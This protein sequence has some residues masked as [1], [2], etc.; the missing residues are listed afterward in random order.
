MKNLP[1]L[2][3]SNADMPAMPVLL[4]GQKQEKGDI[5]YSSIAGLTKREEFAKAAMQGLLANPGG[6]IQSNGMNGWSFANCEVE[7]VASLACGIADALLAALDEST[8]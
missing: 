5:N 8:P 2:P 7:G 6:P 4:N 3:E 1:P